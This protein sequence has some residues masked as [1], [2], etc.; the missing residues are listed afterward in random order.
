MGGEIAIVA[1]PTQCEIMADEI[2]IFRVI[3]NVVRNA[4]QALNK[5]GGRVVVTCAEKAPNVE[6]RVA[7]NGCGIAPDQVQH[8]FEIYHTT[9]DGETR[10][11]ACHP[12]RVTNWPTG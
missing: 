6:I 1:P 8:L 12:V 2:Q 10:E 7:D 5:P 11:G 4:I 9:K 3:Q